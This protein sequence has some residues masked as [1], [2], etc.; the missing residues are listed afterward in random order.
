M[1]KQSLKRQKTIPAP[2]E[3]EKEEELAIIIEKMLKPYAKKLYDIAMKHG[4]FVS[5][6]EFGDFIITVKTS[7]TKNP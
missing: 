7:D 1:K 4:H 6:S 3:K 2:K 5:K